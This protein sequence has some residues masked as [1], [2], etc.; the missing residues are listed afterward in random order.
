MATIQ[1]PVEALDERC[2][3]C[4]CM[5]LKK[6]ELYYGLDKM[7]TQFTCE[8]LHMCQYIKNRIVRG[9]QKEEKSNE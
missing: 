3:T 4:Q 6:V 2:A 5:S 7:I 1:V 8:N 9:E